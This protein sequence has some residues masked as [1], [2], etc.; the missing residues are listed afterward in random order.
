MKRRQSVEHI[1][2]TQ[3]DPQVRDELQRNLLGQADK[4]LLGWPR[5]G[6]VID[7]Q[8]EAL[9][10]ALL[11]NDSADLPIKPGSLPGPIGRD[12]FAAEATA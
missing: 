9:R 3:R 1:A 2:G 7:K 4:S 10:Q 5:R 8:R 11:D 12:E 6:P